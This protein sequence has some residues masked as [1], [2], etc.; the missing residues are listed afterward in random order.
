VDAQIGKLLTALR[1][2][3]RYDNTLIIVTAD[4]GEHLGE[5]GLVDHVFGLYNTTVHIPLL[6]RLPAGIRGGEVDDRVGRL[7]DVLPTVLNACH[8][9]HRS[10]KH[11]GHDLLDAELAD[12]SRVVLSEYYFPIQAFS[13]FSQKDL[14]E[15]MDKVAGYLRRLQALQRGDEKCIWSSD[16]RH[17]YYDLS[18]DPEETANLFDAESPS[19]AAES[20]LAALDETVALYS[21]GVDPGPLPDME[22]VAPGI[23]DTAD[24]E[25]LD[26]LR[27]LGYVE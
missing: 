5:N 10:I 24:P 27:S 13:F 20:C 3:G 15:N 19:G 23:L 16:N 4:H 22:S 26:E 1:E 8:V 2:D 14:A 6:I 11:H 12:E 18:A 21:E 7:V 9:E 25:M 17:A